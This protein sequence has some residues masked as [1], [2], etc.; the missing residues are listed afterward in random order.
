MSL[1][2]EY[3]HLTSLA[4]RDN[5]EVEIFTLKRDLRTIRIFSNEIA[6]AQNI[7]EEGA[8]IRISRDG[9][10]GFAVAN[11]L[12]RDSLERSFKLATSM[13]RASR[14]IPGWHGFP[15]GQDRHIKTITQ[16]LHDTE[17]ASISI[18]ETAQ[19]ALRIVKE[20]VPKYAAKNALTGVLVILFEQF[21]LQNSNGLEYVSETSPIVHSRI[22][23]ES[24]RDKDYC[25]GER[26]FTSN[27]LSDFKPE[28]EVSKLISSTS[29]LL[30][31]PR[32]K[33]PKGKR[34]VILSPESAGAF[35]SYLIGPMITGKS[36]NVGA[37]C[38]TDMLNRR[39]A[40][41]SFSLSDNGRADG[42]IAS[43]S[44]DDEGTPTRSTDVIANG[45]LRN[46]LYDSVSAIGSGAETTGNARRVSD[47]IG[48]SYLAP[49][50]P[51]PTNLVVKPGDSSLD[52]LVEETRSGL[53]IDS[54][55]YTFHLVPE[56]GYFNIVSS[57]PALVIENGRIEGLVRKASIS[58]ELLETLMKIEG[59]GKQAQQS[60]WLGA[61]VA[62]SPHLR[63]KNINVENS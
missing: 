46:F 31:L 45:V 49:P 21:S 57:M 14:S 8:A 59:I 13:A 52:E 7:I 5:A 33:I 25:T 2:E 20:M 3:R 38:F 61:M 40:S 42:G 12:N 30:R 9:R 48:R 1:L 34:E 15:Q 16:M 47:G 10:I 23:L 6:E 17:L 60:S 43:S 22:I 51:L 18:D 37:S 27:K 35:I 53:I 24:R 28:A 19:L 50:E 39:V 36:V 4:N 29:E 62:F 63:I 56:R 26:Q 58:G 44:V 11:D 41:D 55:G 32:K 54:I